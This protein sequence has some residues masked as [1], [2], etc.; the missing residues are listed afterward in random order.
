ME[1]NSAWRQAISLTYGTQEG[2]WFIRSTRGPY[3]VGLWKAISKEIVQLKQDCSFE[4]GDGCR[5]NFWKDIWCGESSL[6][7]SFPKPHDLAGT[8]EAKVAEV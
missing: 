5:I 3:G 7:E 8:K 6:T 4:L 1:D 2:G